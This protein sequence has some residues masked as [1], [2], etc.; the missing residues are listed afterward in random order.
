VTK[1]CELRHREDGSFAVD[2]LPVPTLADL[3]RHAE[4][5]GVVGVYE[6][7]EMY[8]A[9]PELIQLDAEL[10]RIS[11]AG[12]AGRRF[13]RPVRRRRLSREQELKAVAMYVDEGVPHRRIARISVAAGDTSRGCGE[14]Y[15][16]RGRRR[17]RFRRLWNPTFPGLSDAAAA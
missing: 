8:L 11:A 3:V 1:S 13:R 2:G 7:G 17:S 12:Q 5:F 10:R 4:R 9:T 16:R 14:R 15:A 6:T